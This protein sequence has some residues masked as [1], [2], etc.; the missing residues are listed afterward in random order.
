MRCTKPEDEMRRRHEKTR[1]RESRQ[2]K[3]TRENETRDNER[4]RDKTGGKG[5]DDRERRQGRRR[6]RNRRSPSKEKAM[7][8]LI[9]QNYLPSQFGFWPL[10]FW[11]WLAIYDLALQ[12]DRLRLTFVFGTSIKPPS[13]PNHVARHILRS[14]L[15]VQSKS[16]VCLLALCLIIEFAFAFAIWLGLT[17]DHQSI[18]LC[19]LYP[20][21]SLPGRSAP[22]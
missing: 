20:T 17:P 11:F 19:T 8:G 22:A 13:G 18:N 1:P 10:K 21:H 12:I 14:Q 16:R 7:E 2:D 15:K 3:T 9:G 6:V 5:E 4:E